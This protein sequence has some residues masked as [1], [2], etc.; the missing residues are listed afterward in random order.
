MAQRSEAE[1][2]VDL[3]LGLDEALADDEEGERDADPAQHERVVGA[4]RE[5]LPIRQPRQRLGD[6]R[7]HVEEVGERVEQRLD[8]RRRAPEPPRPRH[9]RRDHEHDQ[10]DDAERV[11]LAEP[12]VLEDPEAGDAREHRRVDE[13][14]PVRRVGEIAPWRTSST[15]PAPT[16]TRL[17]AVWTTPSVVSPNTGGSS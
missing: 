13:D 7:H 11:R 3:E 8:V 2:E 4:A 12:A 1:T 6:A 17:S 10:R 5:R 16:A 15:R 14:R 9:E